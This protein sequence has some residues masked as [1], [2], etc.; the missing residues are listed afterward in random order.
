MCSTV[1]RVICALRRMLPYQRR[2]A[3][4]VVAARRVQ[5][6][7]RRTMPRARGLLRITP[8]YAA[9]LAS[10]CPRLRVMRERER[11]RDVVER[12]PDACAVHRWRAIEF[13]A[14]TQC[15]QAGGAQRFAYAQRYHDKYSER[16]ALRHARSNK[17]HVERT[18]AARW[19][20]LLRDHQRVATCLSVTRCARPTRDNATAPR[21]SRTMKMSQPMRGVRR[22]SPPA[23]ERYAARY[24]RYRVRRVKCVTSTYV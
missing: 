20:C 13:V 14:A 8:L 16:V 2:A 23:V 5:T 9:M 21:T 11:R 7:L 18:R 4:G 15:R 24:L 22:R 19:R 10:T 12:A 3:R 1:P 6:A 17:Y